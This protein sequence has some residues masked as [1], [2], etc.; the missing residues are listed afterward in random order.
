MR[1][2]VI[3]L[4]FTLGCAAI[5]CPPKNAYYLVTTEAGEHKVIMV[6]EGYFDDSDNWLTL[7]ELERLREQHLMEERFGTR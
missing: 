4:L 2:I 3:I 6:D 7:E 5:P 1:L